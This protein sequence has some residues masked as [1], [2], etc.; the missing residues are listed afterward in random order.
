MPKARYPH[1][2][3]F[4]SRSGTV[5]WYVR[6]GNGPKIR[7]YGAYGSEEFEANYY[8][9]MSGALGQKPKQKTGEQGT[10]RWLVDMWKQSSDW[11]QTAPSTRKQ[12][13][14]VLARVIK[15]AGDIDYKLITEAKIREGRDRRKDTPGAANFFVKVMRALFRWAKEND[16][17][18]VDPARD[19]KQIRVKTDGFPPWT[20]EEVALYRERWPLGTRE[21]LALEILLNTGLRRGDVVRLGRQHVKDGVA[22]I[23]AEKTGVTLYIPIAPALQEAI[24]AGPTGDLSFIVTEYGKPMVKE[25]FG[26]WFR[27]ACDAAG[28]RKSSHGLRKL[29]ATV[30]A[31]SSGSEHE[32]QALFGWRTNSQS[33]VY[34]REANKRQ[35]ALQAAMKLQAGLEQK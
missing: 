33:A 35:L 30:L 21:R 10:L 4:P 7:V 18:A 19:V 8:A 28:V 1:C 11:G 25:G 16:L 12:R 29:A 26:N 14:L 9:V 20:L 17:V 24:A 15:D 6:K 27:E 3:P 22:T 32:L 31:N 5:R 23:K 13:D 2:Y 34:T